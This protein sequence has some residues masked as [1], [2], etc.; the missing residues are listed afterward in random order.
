MLKGFRDFITKGNVVDLAVA[1]V[2]GTAFGA[3]VTSLVENII[4]PLVSAVAGAPNFDRFAVLTVNGND[5]R[6]GAFITVV[7]NFIIIAATVYFIVVAPM[8]R[9]IARR[10]HILG[11]PQEETPV[12]PQV[13]LL[14]EIRD[15]LR[16]GH[17]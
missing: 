11:I 12:D 14:T 5:V 6:F 13:V 1:V 17:P 8:N 2:I 7:V 4:M 10:N 3:V 16:A 15:T 9:I